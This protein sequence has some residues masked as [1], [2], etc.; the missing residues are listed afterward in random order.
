[1][2]TNLFDKIFLFLII[3]ILLLLTAILVTEFQNFVGLT[4]TLTKVL[5]N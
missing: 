3:L 2:H 5:Q 1:M 4:E